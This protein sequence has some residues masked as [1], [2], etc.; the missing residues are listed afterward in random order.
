MYVNPY[1]NSA[2][3]ELRAA[4]DKLKKKLEEECKSEKPNIQKINKIQ[5]SLYMPDLFTNSYLGNERYRNPW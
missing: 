1:G 5:E 4:V 2:P 3:Y